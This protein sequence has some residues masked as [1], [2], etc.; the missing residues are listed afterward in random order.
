V[1]SLLKVGSVLTAIALTAAITSPALASKNDG[2]S[3]QQIAQAQACDK[4]WYSYN[5][6]AAIASTSSK[7][8]EAAAFMKAAD[9]D[10]AKGKSLGCGWAT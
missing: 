10:K 3:P 6:D 8:K 5:A 7:P 4:V 2:R 1:S 9:K